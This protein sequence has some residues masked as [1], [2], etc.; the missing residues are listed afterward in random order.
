MWNRL[1]FG[2][3]RGGSRHGGFSRP[4]PL[5]VPCRRPESTTM[6]FWRCPMDP[7]RTSA[8]RGSRAHPEALGQS[9][10]SFVEVYVCLEFFVGY[11][12]GV[13]DFLLGVG[14]YLVHRVAHGCRVLFGKV[15]I[16]V[17]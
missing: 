10:S 12:A 6:C 14:D 16:S 3:Y 17:G 13:L 15:E 11:L 9:D 2:R 8:A 4:W 1:G 7:K 5:F